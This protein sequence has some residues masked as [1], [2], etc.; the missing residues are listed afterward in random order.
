MTGY[1]RPVDVRVHVYLKGSDTSLC[2]ETRD[3]ATPVTD[4]DHDDTPW[5]DECW[6]TFI[7]RY[8]REP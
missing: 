5:C 2:G 8:G 4:P 3:G 6:G 1:G 7:D